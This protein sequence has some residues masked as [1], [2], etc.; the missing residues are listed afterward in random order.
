MRNLLTAIVTVLALVEI[1]AWMHPRMR[2]S[3]IDD[4]REF[5]IVVSDG[6]ADE[7]YF[8][9]TVEGCSAEV[10]DFGIECTNSWFGRTDR[11]W[12]TQGRQEPVPFRDA[13]RGS[14][15]RFEARVSDR[16]GKAVASASYVTTRSLR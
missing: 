16:A 6:G 3:K 4:K 7:T 10:T 12:R 5:Q 11:E 15:L 9:L 8:W 14:I 13:P 2:I 1:A